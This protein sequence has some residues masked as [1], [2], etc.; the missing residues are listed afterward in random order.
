MSKIT[1]KY[2]LTIPKAIAEKS[3]FAPGDEV[4]CESAGEVIRVAHKVL[5]REPQSTTDRLILFD[6]STERQA[7][8]QRS[9]RKPKSPQRGWTR[10]DLYER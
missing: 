9:A 6:L 7:H 2:Q 1:S 5:K 8:R 3:G 4:E 10:E